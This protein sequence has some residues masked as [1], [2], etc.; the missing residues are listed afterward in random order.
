MTIKDN[1][2]REFQPGPELSEFWESR[3][4]KALE[5]RD[6]CRLHYEDACDSVD[7]AIH[8]ARKQGV[9]QRTIMARISAFQE[10]ERY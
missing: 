6:S 9:S 7:A 3:L 1:N 2:G 5:R 10:R 8:M 4:N